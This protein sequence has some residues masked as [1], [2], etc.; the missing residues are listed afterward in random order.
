[1]HSNLFRHPLNQGS[2]DLVISDGVLHHTSDCAGAFRSIAGLVKPG[3]AIVIGLYNR[4]GRLPTL[5]RRSLIK[6]LGATG[7]SFKYRE[8]DE[9]EMTRR[10]VWLRQQYQHPHETRHSMTEI[11]GWFDAAG[12]D[13]TAS[14]PTIGDREVD[15]DMRLFDPRSAGTSWDRLSSEIEML[16]SGGA[17]DGRCIMIGRRRR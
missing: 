11:L 16:L 7:I 5:W 15:A 17:G 14:I 3:G 12:F 13:Y 10:Q 8:R 4:L 6:V 9:S 2:F 1:M